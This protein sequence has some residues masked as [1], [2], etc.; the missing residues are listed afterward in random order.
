MAKKKRIKKNTLDQ[1]SEHFTWE[2]CENSNTADRL[3]I[4]NTIK[5][6]KV[7]NNIILLCEKVLE[8]A[9]KHFDK[10]IT[11]S[12]VYRNIET[13]L[14]VGGSQNSTHTLGCAVDFIIYGIDNYEVAE[15]LINETECTKVILEHYTLGYKNKG[16]VHAEYRQERADKEKESLTAL[17]VNRANINKLKTHHTNP[18]KCIYV[19]GLHKFK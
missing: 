17:R 7:R 19:T 6:D 5:D 1:P 11:P 8:P 2:E 18:N 12:S 4:D 15:Y 16:W 14:A 3:G 9:R 10:P 13:N